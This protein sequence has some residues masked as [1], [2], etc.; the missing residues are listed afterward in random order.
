MLRG[1]PIETWA[2]LAVIAFGWWWAIKAGF[3]AVYG[4]LA[5]GYLIWCVH[6]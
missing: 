3:G 5:L 1:V 6:V 4:M 2:R